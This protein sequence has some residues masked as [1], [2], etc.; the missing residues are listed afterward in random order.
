MKTFIRILY[1]KGFFDNYAQADKVL[2]DFL[3]VARRRGN[4]L[5]QVYDDVQ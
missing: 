4:L 3:F 1:D 2:G 5:E